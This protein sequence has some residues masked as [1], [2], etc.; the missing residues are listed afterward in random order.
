MT[1]IGAAPPAGTA[2]K[3]E[4]SARQLIATR[5][6]DPKGHRLLS[7]VLYRQGRNADA[8]NAA[9]A[10]IMA[11]LQSPLLSGAVH[12]LNHGELNKAEALIRRRLADD[13][14]DAM[15]LTMM[16][17][18][19]S[20]LF[21]YDH[22]EGFLKRALAIAPDFE[23]CRLKLGDVL[24]D[25]GAVAEALS[26]YEAALARNPDCRHALRAKIRIYGEIGEYQAAIDHHHRLLA[27]DPDQPGPLVAYGNTLKTLGRS[28]DAVTA[29]RQAI[30]LDPA[31]TEPWWALSNLK[32]GQL[33]ADDVARM[34]SLLEEIKAPGQRLYLHFALGKALED[35]GDY[36]ASFR[37]YLAGNQARLT[38]APHDR[39][40]L[41]RQVERTIAFFT[42]ELIAAR[43]GQGAPARDPIFILGMPRAGSTLLEQILA[44][45]SAI[46]GTSEL[47]EIPSMARRLHGQHWQQTSANYPELLG[48]LDPAT[49]RTLGERYLAG[50]ALHRK[51]DR[52]FF[53]DK[54]PA[55][56]LHIGLIHLILPNATII[57]ARREPMACGFANFKQHFARGQSF[58]CSLGDIG[59]Y[60]RH[61][62]KLIEH[63][64]AVMPGR[65]IRLQHERLLDDPES[66]IRRLMHE[67]GLEYEPGCL[68]FHENPR[69]VRTPSSEQVRRPINRDAVDLW[70]H[71][72]PW[73][74]ELRQALG[75]LALTED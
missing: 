30:A 60:Y 29:Y 12:H 8:E 70:R 47:P 56:W 69:P 25:A 68:R 72:A 36:A 24:H 34:E 61:Y 43:S 7:Q 63:F 71:Y 5:P 51:T 75:P 66:E 39:Q 55:N 20:R 59:H 54:T 4:A 37:H 28:A 16:G 40:Q 73:L 65:V 22:A 26:V 17:D 44:S 13:P 38:I 50:A 52:P 35:I 19:T 67:I 48:D 42:P 18:L 1:P 23:D 49:Y 10:A 33:N 64:D 31:Q 14:D 58:S 57:D 11:S 41:E 53:I 62:V 3:A 2:D 74:D 27:L 15:A 21:I 45:H 6:D 9:M 32:A 46:E